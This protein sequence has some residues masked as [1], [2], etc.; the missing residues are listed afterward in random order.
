MD[1]AKAAYHA[2][3]QI[4]FAFS[5]FGCILNL[6]WDVANFRIYVQYDA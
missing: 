3:V 5:P 6:A 2:F 1:A 4:I